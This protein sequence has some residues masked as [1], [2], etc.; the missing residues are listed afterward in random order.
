NQRIE[1]FSKD[2]LLWD[3]EEE[4]FVARHEK[5]GQKTKS[6]LKYLLDGEIAQGSTDAITGN[7]LYSMNNQLANY[8]GGGAN[9]ESG[10]WPGPK[11]ALK[12]FAADGKEGSP[13]D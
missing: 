9:Y 3:D 12:T 6:K 10:A 4:A 13:Q 7:Q 1:D 11:F 5:D 2:A 8:F